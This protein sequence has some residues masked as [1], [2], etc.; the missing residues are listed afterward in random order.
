MTVVTE[1][2][3][4]SRL[5]KPEA[6]L[7]LS[8]KNSFE[9]AKTRLVNIFIANDVPFNVEKQETDSGILILRV[10]NWRELLMVAAVNRLFL[11]N[12]VAF[13]TGA[14]L[15]HIAA[16]LHLLSRM[17]GEPD[18]RFRTRIQ[19][20]A[21]NKSGGRLAGYKT[22]AMRASIDIVNVGTWV[23][24]THIMEPVV[25]LALMNGS[26]GQWVVDE[27]VPPNTSRLRRASDTGMGVPSSLLVSSVQAHLD[28]EHI[29]QATDIVAVQ[30]IAPIATT[31]SYTIHHRSGPDPSRLRAASANAVA[32]LVDDRHHP[33]RDLP[34]TA[35]ISGASVG[36]VEKVSMEYPLADVVAGNGQTVFV[37]QITVRSVLSNE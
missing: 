16:T 29:K 27:A 24:R 34:F 20:E 9:E 19:L 1:L 7:T 15:D 25:R 32:S 31:I 33:H 36:G 18:E 37:S 4:M 23:D 5:G 17:D 11:Q 21:E 14:S 22:E 10:N 28:Q 12:L 3:D 6:L 30:A 8:F 13:A 35:I 26:T 2:L